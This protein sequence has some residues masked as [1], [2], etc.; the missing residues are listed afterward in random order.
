M[1][2]LPWGVGRIEPLVFCYHA[3]SEDWHDQLA[4][5]PTSF[6]AQMRAVLRAGYEPMP[7]DRILSATGKV[8]HVTFDDAFC[9]IR[10][11]LDL[12]AS[13]GVPATVFAC[14]DLAD[15]GRPLHAGELGGSR[16]A[17]GGEGETMAW[18]ELRLLAET[19]VEIGSHTCSH[20][21]LTE[22]SDHDLRREL[23]DSRVR[24][25]DALGR[26][27]PYLSYPFGEQDARV[28]AAARAA[29]YAAAFAQA[30]WP[31]RPDRYAVYRV[32][33]YR[34]DSLRRV[35]LKMSRSGRIAAA[36]HRAV[37]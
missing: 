35:A 36:V 28:R 7:V 11:A 34:R 4:V 2:S 29:G 37:R 15:D 9:N 8:F 25:E 13:L 31:Y 10:G 1:V 26:P 12:L 20:P 19:G 33:V 16:A 23:R 24:L 17:P 18:D 14:S 21:H 5:R 32:S 27:C 22:L 6:E 30:S 3:V